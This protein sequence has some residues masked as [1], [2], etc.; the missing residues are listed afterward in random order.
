MEAEAQDRPFDAQAAADEFFNRGGAGEPPPE[1]DRAAETGNGEQE[2]QGE[3]HAEEPREDLSM[4][5]LRAMAERRGEA[6]NRAKDGRD[7]AR[8]RVQELEAQ[9]QELQSNAEAWK[10][11]T[12]YI[13]Q[14]GP[15]PQMAVDNMAR[16]MQMQQQQGQQDFS[17]YGNPQPQQPM[18]QPPPSQQLWG[19]QQ[20]QRPTMDN[21]TK[22]TLNQIMSR[23]DNMEADRTQTRVESAIQKELQRQQMP[24]TPQLTELVRN[25][26]IG[27]NITSVG[28]AIKMIRNTFGE[29]SPGAQ[30]AA[31]E[32]ATL[33]PLQG[34][35]AQ[36]PG[37]PVTGASP[38]GRAKGFADLAEQQRKANELVERVLASQD[39]TDLG[40]SWR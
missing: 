21:D 39:V 3:Q 34:L 35:G 19:G 8:Q 24:L 23:L 5:E 10:P 4:E 26:M 20:N 9:V 38:I 11:I 14:F 28:Q 6:Y 22:Q 16:M 32:A 12:D 15:T 2:P 36:P 7:E 1:T 25:V 40:G 17:E 29:Q 37:T 27:G 13:G 18:Y 33:N 30:Q 31:Q